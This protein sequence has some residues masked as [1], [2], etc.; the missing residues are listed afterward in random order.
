[1]FAVPDAIGLMIHAMRALAVLLLLLAMFMPV[2]GETARAGELI[3]RKTLFGNPE[4][5][6]PMISPD[7][8]LIAFT[9]ARDGVMNLWVAPV[10]DLE[11]ARPLTREK[12]RPIMEFKWASNST[13]L[14]YFQDQEGD[15]NF[16]LFS[17]E[18]SSG[19]LRDLTPYKGVRAT[20]IGQSHRHPDELVI[21]LNNRDSKWHDAWLVNVVSGASRLLLQNEGFGEFITDRDLNIRLGL[22]PLQDGGNRV[23]LRSGTKWRRLMTIAG[24]DAFNTMPLQISEDGR[25]VFLMDS[26]GRDKSALTALD[27][28]TAKTTVL[29]SSTRSDLAHVL[30]DP[31]S[32]KPLAAAFEYARLD[33]QAIDPSLKPDLEALGKQ[34]PG[35]WF[36]LSQTDDNRRWVIWID[37]PGKPIRFG[38]WNR[39]TRT[40]QELYTAR[41]AL[42]NAQLPLTSPHVI[43]SRDGL[44]LVSYLTLP[45]NTTTAGR[46]RP[47]PMVLMVHGGPW[48]RDSMAYNPYSAWLSDRGYAV[49]SVNFR[50]STGFGKRFVNAGDREWGGRMHDDLIDAVDWAIAKGIADPDRIAIYGASYGGYAALVGLTKTPTRFACAVD[51]VGP[52]NLVTLLRNIPIYWQAYLENFKRRVGDPSTPSG[53]KFLEQRSPLFQAD[54]IRRPLLIGQGA[55]DPRVTQREADQIVNKMQARGL[56]VTYVLYADEGHGFARPQNRLSFNA[57]TEAFLASCLGGKAEPMGDDFEGSS[58]SVPAGKEYI[59]GLA[60]ALEQH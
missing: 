8:R 51:V 52:S 6:A 40:L 30:A 43:R 47:M 17:V 22:K 25:A 58:V 28:V 39:D 11:E 27:L 35:Y 2:V 44:D 18:V 37:N 45:A 34:V 24:D 32:G 9:A 55:N 31:K 7:G 38:L 26:R 41:P 57:I 13:H 56:P 1:M 10:D 42:E 54:R 14:L 53:R 3:P 16:H 46:M 21:G 50:G 48:A 12:R 4:R 5:A 19:Q 33:W 29:A 36:P 60:K 15:E 20:I 49:L 59:R 23:F